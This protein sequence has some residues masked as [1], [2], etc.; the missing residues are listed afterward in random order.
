MPRCITLLTDFGHRD[1]YVGEMHAVIT[2]IAPQARVIDLTHE[3]APQ[4]VLQGAIFLANAVESCPAGTIHVA[5]VDPGV[6]SDRA[7]IA[8]QAGAWTFVAPD[9]GLLTVVLQRY[10]LLAAVELTNT[11]YHRSYVSAT[12]HGRDI[13]CPVA[14]HLANGVAWENLG[15][16]ITRPLHQIPI[17]V[18]K[19]MAGQ[20]RGEVLWID[21]FGNLVTNLEASLL[22]DTM[23]SVRVHGDSLIP[24]VRCYADVA[25]GQ[26]LALIGSSGR[27]E[28]AIRNGSAAT[29]FSAQVGEIM[30]LDLPTHSVS[31]PLD[32]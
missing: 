27:L 28:I 11:T 22:S 29:T 17:P 15:A 19:V 32:P 6:G 3:V 4:N 9:N 21:H 14:A 8:V 10:P 26:P 2:G 7:A 16:G 23:T 13:F 1:T 31:A 30:T 12:F 24:R 20:L 5:V 25:V 18:P